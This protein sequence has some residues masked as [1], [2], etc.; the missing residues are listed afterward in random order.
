[1]GAGAAARAMVTLA[2]IS[3]LHCGEASH[4]RLDRA[5]DAINSL[6]CDVVVVT[7]D[8]THSGRRREYAVARRFLADL[9][10]PV[11]GCP[12]NHDAP[13]FD[14][15]ARALAPF[16]RFDELGLATR[17]D[18]KCGSV[19]VRSLNSA[20]AIQARLDW[21]QGAYRRRDF[22]NLSNSFV[23]GARFRIIACHHP[24][25]GPLQMRMAISTRGAV[26]A[27]TLLRGQ[28]VI[29]C[30]HL[31][32]AADFAVEGLPHLR[33]M[34]APTLASKRERG[35]APGFRVIEF[36]QSLTVADWRWRGDEYSPAAA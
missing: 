18:S 11:V 5:R 21:S 14:P 24:P 7:G 16:A 15:M 33:V 25:H 34:T 35:E 8:I 13:V 4:S 31:H 20:R 6:G 32:H 22:S 28:H 36:S 2:H 23:E 9:N 10:T 1:M 29:L 17:W 19:S 27:L 26:R 3:D 12:G 30:G